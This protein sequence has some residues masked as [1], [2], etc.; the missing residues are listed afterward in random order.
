M[1]VNKKENI[2]RKEDAEKNNHEELKK[3]PFFECP[4]NAT[5]NTLINHKNIFI[6]SVIKDLNRRL[7]EIVI[8][9][10]KYPVFIDVDIRIHLKHI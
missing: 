5:H 2:Y 3:R 8:S 7:A 10:I 1:S 4:I 6:D 9:T